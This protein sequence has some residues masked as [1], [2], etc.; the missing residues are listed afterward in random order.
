MISSSVNDLA[1]TPRQ[2]QNKFFSQ[3]NLV[4]ETAP[5]KPE[6]SYPQNHENERL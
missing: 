1:Y 2:I 6:I 3:L 5:I 4:L